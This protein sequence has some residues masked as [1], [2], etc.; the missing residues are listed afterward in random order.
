M[1]RTN[2]VA[3]AVV[4][5]A[6]VPLIW[7]SAAFACQVL[8]TLQVTPNPATAGAT[9]TATGGN[10]SASA[11]ASNVDIHLDTR[12]G[13]ILAS[14][15][16]AAGTNAISVT[17]A[18]PANIA[19]GYHTLIATQSINGVPKSGTPGRAALQ[20]T[21]AGTAV[22]ASVVSSSSLTNPL[23]AGPVVVVLAAFGLLARKR[24][25]NTLAA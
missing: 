17:F 23:V 10:Y 5:V 2:R 3:L 18:L 16:P 13:R 25:Q 21:P 20:I 8:A 11:S 1:K 14:T 24:R 4:G 9:V 22:A 7:A 19:T 6:M 12:S 15:K